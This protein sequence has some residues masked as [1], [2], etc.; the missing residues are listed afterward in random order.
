MRLASIRPVRFSSAEYYEEI[1][2]DYPHSRQARH[3]PNSLGRLYRSAG[4][5]EKAI[6]W[7]ERQLERSCC[8]MSGNRALSAQAA[9]YLYHVEDYSKAAELFEEYLEK[10]PDG[11]RAEFAP[12]HLAKC[13]EKLGRRVQD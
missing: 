1:M 11:E 5:Y 10:Y 4:E 3:L 6:D 13:Y 2:Q 12:I 8:A 7:Y 9:I